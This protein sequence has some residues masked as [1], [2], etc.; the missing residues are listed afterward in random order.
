MNEELQIIFTA[1]TD[2]L[3]QGVDEAKSAVEDVKNTGENTG[4]Q[5]TGTFEK[6]GS[7]IIAAFSVKA[8]MDFANA[9]WEA[10]N[11]QEQAEIKLEQL[12]GNTGATDAQIQSIKDLCAE[13]QEVGVIGDEVAMAGASMLAQF[14]A[15]EEQIKALLPSIEDMA[16][17]LYGVNVSQEQMA[18]ASKAVSKALEGNYGALEKLGV[19]LTDDEKAWLD[20]ASAEE[21]ADFFA[22]K[23]DGT[24]GGMNQ[25]MA[26]TSQG[27]VQQMK[28]AFGDLMEVIGALIAP[29][30]SV[31]AQLASALIPVLQVVVDIISTYLAPAIQLITDVIFPALQVV[32]D[33]LVLPAF[34]AIGEIASAIS[35]IAVNN[36]SKMAEEL[37]KQWENIKSACSTAWNNIK[38]LASSAWEGIKNFI[39]NPIQTAKS[40]LSSVIEG[41]KSTCAS[42][43]DSIK[44]KAS[45]TWESIK[46]AITR[47]IETA[48]NTV[49]NVIDRIK[50]FFNFSWSLPHLK[51]P[52]I[53]ISGSFSLLPPSAP[54]FSIQWYKQGGIFD[55]PTMIGVGEA[56]REAVMPLE[57]NTGWINELA[58]KIN[59]LNSGNGKLEVNL[60][61]DKQK[62]GTVAINSIND[63]IKQ[64]G[65][66]P[67]AI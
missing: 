10:Y 45:S 23:L 42:V 34:E 27:A 6:L 36:V 20:T 52:H 66:I 3:K 41:I 51:M 64:S 25:T 9:C 62:L 22:G 5:L 12:M 39:L 37:S 63:I 1:I 13:L 48:K 28:N 55:K 40:T 38:S 18:S 11:V 56:G 44:S 30:I 61:I 7:A 58:S 59:T 54:N 16:V 17:S 33:T 57:H 14:G 53:Q 43:W 21:R 47:P 8:V 60:V 2:G 46:T 49:K 29:I 65:T 32:I 4:S 19:V 31:V 24:F 35:E 67:L 15:N 26:S 50:G